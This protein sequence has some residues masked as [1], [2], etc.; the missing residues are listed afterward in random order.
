MLSIRR[1]ELP[2]IAGILLAFLG[3]DGLIA[4]SARWECDHLMIFADTNGDH[5]INGSDSG[6]LLQGK[7]LSDIDLS[8][9]M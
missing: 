3:C 8:T 2:G 6:V 5:Q 4:P 1:R 9:I 7:T